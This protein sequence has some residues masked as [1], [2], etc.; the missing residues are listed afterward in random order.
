LDR[1]CE[2][3]RVEDDGL[4]D[5]RLLPPVSWQNV[6]LDGFVERCGRRVELNLSGSHGARKRLRSDRR[7][8]QELFCCNTC[9]KDLGEKTDRS[10]QMRRFERRDVEVADQEEVEGICL[11]TCPEHDDVH[12]DGQE[13]VRELHLHTVEQEAVA[14]RYI[15][16]VSGRSRAQKV[17]WDRNRENLDV[18]VRR[19]S[20]SR[21]LIVGGK[22]IRVRR[23]RKDSKRRNVVDCAE[24][25]II[26]YFRYILK[27]TI[28]VKVPVHANGGSVHSDARRWRVK[29]PEI[30][31][32][33]NLA[34]PSQLRDQKVQCS[35]P[36]HG[37]D[38]CIEDHEN[39]DA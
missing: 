3:E 17:R 6:C 5:K 21:D 31:F 39:R 23:V 7:V 11:Q 13:R 19:D 1:A 4:L 16:P 24:L 27:L 8:E 25:A 33:R 30:L 14:K 9:N 15:G 32:S 22:E 20:E 36:E 12:A 29:R 28:V 34:D 26:P 35:G 2:E 10:F 37:S 18:H 38:A